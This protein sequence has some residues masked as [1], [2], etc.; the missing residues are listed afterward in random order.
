[1]KQTRLNNFMENNQRHTR[2]KYSQEFNIVMKNFLHVC[3]VMHTLWKCTKTA[4]SEALFCLNFTIAFLKIHFT[5]YLLVGTFEGY[6]KSYLDI[7]WNLFCTKIPY[8][9]LSLCL[10][11]N[12]PCRDHAMTTLLSSWNNV[13]FFSL[14][15]HFQ[16]KNIYNAPLKN[17]EDPARIITL[18]LQLVV[19]SEH[20]LSTKVLYA[21]ALLRAETKVLSYNSIQ[22]YQVENDHNDLFGCC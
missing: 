17:A 4:Y 18:W 2:V 8:V 12:I 19:T 21:S 5:C 1:M 15:E 14:V 10:T 20:A 16:K 3:W 11:E 7:C 22:M 9:Y 13:T 6:N